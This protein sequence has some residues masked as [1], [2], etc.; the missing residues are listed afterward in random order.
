MLERFADVI[1]DELSKKLNGL[2]NVTVW[3]GNSLARLRELLQSGESGVLPFVFVSTRWDVAQDN[4]TYAVMRDSGEIVTRA[5]DDTALPILYKP[6]LGVCGKTQDEVKEIVDALRS[7]FTEGVMQ[8]AFVDNKDG[9]AIPLFIRIAD[10]D[11]DIEPRGGLSKNA[12]PIECFSSSV[13]FYP[14]ATPKPL[15]TS[16]IDFGELKRNRDNQYRFVQIAQ[17]CNKIA[18]PYRIESWLNDYHSLVDPSYASSNCSDDIVSL[19]KMSKN[20]E[21]PPRDIFERCMSVLIPVC[22]DLFDRYTSKEPYMTTAAY[23]MDKTSRIDQ[24]KHKICKHLDLPE[25]E[26]MQIQRVRQP[27]ESEAFKYYLQYMDE[28]PNLLIQDVYYKYRQHLREK[29]KHDVEL[30]QQINNMASDIAE[31]APQAY[32]EEPY[33]EPASSGPS[34]GSSIIGSILGNAIGNYGVRKELRNQTRFMEEEARETRREQERIRN[35]EKRERA[36][37]SQREWDAVKR[38]NDERRRKGEPLLPL[39]PRHYW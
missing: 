13:A 32:H 9:D 24:L 36:L 4:R 10:E 22:P 31:P 5:Y 17:W 37:Q 25:H 27:R 26:D 33:Y 1:V 28:D 18:N 35:E 2:N 29:E 30:S 8:K 6:T 21:T 16:T 34:L 23:I 20:N 39:P 19:R 11:V 3:G 7:L 38:A 14:A 15:L 12:F